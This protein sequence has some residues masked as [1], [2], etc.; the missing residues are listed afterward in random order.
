MDVT[1]FI[2][3]QEYVLNNYDY[4]QNITSFGYTRLTETFC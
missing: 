3:E 2:D 1:H 4:I